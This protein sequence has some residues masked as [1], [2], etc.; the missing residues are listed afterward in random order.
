MGKK[1]LCRP[2]FDVLAIL[3]AA[4]RK[5][6][7]SPP[8]RGMPFRDSAEAVDFVFRCGC[9]TRAGRRLTRPESL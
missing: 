4:F 8:A 3:R 1:M 5:L 6:G 9:L 2:I 7:S